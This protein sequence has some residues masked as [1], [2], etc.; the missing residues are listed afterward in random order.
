MAPQPVY[1]ELIQRGV[2]V[3][4][5][6]ENGDHLLV[7]VDGNLGSNKR[8]FDRPFR[9]K[10]L[11]QL[12]ESASLG[13]GQEE[14][15][16][17]GLHGAPAEED[18]VR[19]PSDALKAHRPRELV[20]QPGRVDA[21]VR[22][23][24]ALGAELKGQDLDGVQGLEGR[25]ADREDGPKDEDHGNDGAGSVTVRFARVVV[26]ASGGTDADPAD[27]AGSHGEEH[28]GPAP[29]ALDESGSHEGEAELETCV[30]K[31]DPRLDA[32][33]LVANC[34]EHGRKEVRQRSVACPLREDDKDAVAGNAVASGA[35]VE[36]LSVVP[37]ALVRAF[38]VE[39]CLVLVELELDP[40]GGLV[41]KTM[42][43]GED[44]FGFVSLVVDI[45]PARRFGDEKGTDTD[46]AG[47]EELE[48]D[49]DLPGSGAREVQSSEDGAC[50]EDGAHEPESIAV[51]RG[52]A[53][54]HGMARLDDVD[55]A[56][57][58]SDG[59]AKAEAESAS[60]ELV[61]GGVHAG[62]AGDD[63][64]NDDNKGADEHAETTTPGVDGWA[65]EGE[66]TDAADL[67]HG[68]D[69]ASP[70]LS[71]LVRTCT[72]EVLRIAL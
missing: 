49:G 23:G 9:R 8:S 20:Q 31:I 7:H 60:H 32:V 16:D 28:E 71:T 67:I 4:S 44:S 19:V 69:E 66:G 27:A 36:E 64:A 24:H 29:D 55:G 59:D 48:P 38:S 52:H 5:A 17:G 30:A 65:D 26:G 13:L 62:G 2:W 68:A 42:P 56:G 57:S 21:Q 53:A 6:L 33:G 15:D 63:S 40:R 58:G 46:E 72:E 50:G 51:G 41:T 45:A 11:I 39:V 25:D 3:H 54:E 35:G 22:E 1:G 37:P 12:F 10:D 47:E 61:D 34:I 43:L 18:K 70:Y 14:V